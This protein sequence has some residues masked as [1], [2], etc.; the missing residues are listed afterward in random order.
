MYG[1]ASTSSAYSIDPEK[2]RLK[3]QRPM[4][5]KELFLP[6]LLLMALF[7]TGCERAGPL[8]EDTPASATLSAIQVR[9][10]DTSCAVSGCHAGSNPQLGM[11]LEA[12]Q[13]FASIVNVPSVERADLLRIDPGNP[14]DSYLLKKIRGDGDIVGMR[15][16]LGR[17]NLSA[18]DIE[19]VRQWIQD[20]ALDN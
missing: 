8:E 3:K 1:W 14:D 19:L 11:S 16:P 5:D 17:S 18:D 9:I 20:G 7:V 12:G 2:Q 13:A 6:A 15:M 10:F 4:P